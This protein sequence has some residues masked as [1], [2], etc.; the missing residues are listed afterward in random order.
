MSTV[1]SVPLPTVREA[2]DTPA[3]LIHPSARVLLTAEVQATLDRLVELLENE[4]RTQ[5]IP[6]SEVE[7]HGFVD[8]EKDTDTV[9]VTPWVAVPSQTALVYWDH[10]GTALEAWTKQLPTDAAAIVAEQIAVEVRWET[11]GRAA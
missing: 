1:T 6:I 5:G 11:D 2:S 4:A 10:L 7:V 8:P 9:I 3:L